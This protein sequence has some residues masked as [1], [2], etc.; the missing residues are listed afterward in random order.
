MSNREVSFPAKILV[1]TQIPNR[2]SLDK[3]QGSAVTI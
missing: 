3:T 1:I 2:E